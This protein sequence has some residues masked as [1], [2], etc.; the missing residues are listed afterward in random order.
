M[1]NILAGFE[2]QRPEI[3]PKKKMEAYSGQKELPEHE[4]ERRSD[5]WVRA[6]KTGEESPGS[7]VYAGS[8]TDMVNLG[9]V[10]LRA[11]KKVSFDTE[12]GKITNDKSANKYLTRDYRKGW[13]I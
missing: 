6:I 2:G 1:E 7:F 5:T 12:T 4:P 3:I 13:E 10:A 9:G 11:G 8:I